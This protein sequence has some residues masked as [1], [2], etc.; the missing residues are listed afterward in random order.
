MFSCLLPSRIGRWVV[1]GPAGLALALA[2]LATA[3]SAQQAT[4]R[5]T[6]VS[7]NHAYAGEDLAAL[8]SV[9]GDAAPYCDAVPLTSTA[10]VSCTSPTT[11]IRMPVGYHLAVAFP[12]CGAARYDFRIGPDFGLGGAIF[13][14]NA[15][16]QGAQDDLWWNLSWANPGEL[17]QGGASLGNGWHFLDVVGFENCC[18]G[19]AALQFKVN[20]GAWQYVSVGA[21]SL[22]DADGDGVADACD[23]CPADPANDADGDGLCAG[24]DNCP[25]VANSD[26]IDTDGD[27]IGDA[28]DPDD[29]GDGVLD[30]AD[31]CPL[32]PNPTQSDLDGDGAGDACDLDDD[33]DGVRD[34]ADACMRTAPG[35]VVNAQGCSIADLCPCAAEWKNHGAYVSCVARTAEAFLAASSIDEAAKD[36]AVSAAATSVCG[37]K[38]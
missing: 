30:V 17:L 8:L 9:I 27:G 15:L 31:N 32:V 24:A 14:D 18:G 25:A 7:T 4:I 34:D 21:L 12:V 35:A 19:Y 5:F 2:M 11:P 1:R 16:L 37:Q 3:A 26:Q 6:E 38:N 20:D 22:P 10:R 29:D 36:A 23:A 28:C 13:L 33:N